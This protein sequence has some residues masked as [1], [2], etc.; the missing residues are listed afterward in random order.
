MDEKLASRPNP[1]KSSYSLATETVND[2]GRY[3]F[4]HKPLGFGTALF[5]QVCLWFSIR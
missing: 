1:P 4:I 2:K 5:M 3:R